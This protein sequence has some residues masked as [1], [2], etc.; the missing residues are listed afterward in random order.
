MQ[1]IPL[2]TSVLNVITEIIL[3]V[4][5]ADNLNDEQKEFREEFFE[6][7]L[8]HLSDITGS[9]RSK[10]ISNFCKL[11]QEHAIPLCLQIEILGEIILHLRDKSI[12]ARKAAISAVTVFLQY[13][14]FGAT[15][16]L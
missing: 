10:V 12:A 3:K 16:S 8:E 13:N 5:T 4:L 6:I 2:R 15:V 14:P 11:Q 7:L 9:V 1:S